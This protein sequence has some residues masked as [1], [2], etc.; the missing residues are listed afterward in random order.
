[1]RTFLP[2]FEPPSSGSVD[3]RDAVTL[4]ECRV[5]HL[6]QLNLRFCISNVSECFGFRC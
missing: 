4:E 1:M 6:T 2:I 5:F 3:R